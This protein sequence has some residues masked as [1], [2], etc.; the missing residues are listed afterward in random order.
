MA[1]A[2]PPLPAETAGHYALDERRITKIVATGFPILAV[3]T[4]VVM[5]VLFGIAT[6]I[7]T[8]A[9][10]GLLAGIAL[11]WTSLRV[12][13]GDAPLS[14]ELLALHIQRNPADALASRKTMLVRALKDLENEQAIGKLQQD[15]YE[16]LRSKYRADLTLVLQQMDAVLQPHR[17]KAEAL[18]NKFLAKD[19][20]SVNATIRAVSQN[21][22]ACEKC[23]VSNDPDAEFCK[24]CGAKLSDVSSEV[25]VTM[26]GS[27]DEG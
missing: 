16:S 21:P 8:L 7:L 23:N 24:K 26:E 9:T 6:A 5:G 4:A 13:S 15:D 25:T 1:D 11:F 27:H 3:L 14:E 20:P 12:L 19:I 18:A 2:A 22:K 17:A 10:S